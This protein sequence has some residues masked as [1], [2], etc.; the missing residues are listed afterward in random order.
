MH[1][2]GNTRTLITNAR[3]L[4]VTGKQIIDIFANTHLLLIKA[5]ISGTHT[6]SDGSFV[7][8]NNTSYQSCVS[9]NSGS[10]LLSSSTDGILLRTSTGTTKGRISI[11]TDGQLVLEWSILDGAPTENCEIQITAIMHGGNN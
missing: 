5:Y 7:K 3:N 8:R 6:S 10:F 9:H 2:E 1:L 11:P 4:S